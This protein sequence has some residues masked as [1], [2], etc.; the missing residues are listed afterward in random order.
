MDID[1]GDHE[2]IS[3]LVVIVCTD[4]QKVLLRRWPT[5][6]GREPVPSTRFYVVAH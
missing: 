5:S 2:A 6:F 3:L 1:L 4:G